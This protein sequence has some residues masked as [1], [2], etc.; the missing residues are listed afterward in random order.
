MASVDG[1]EYAAYT[2][3]Q[4]MGWPNELVGGGFGKDQFWIML[5][6]PAHVPPFYEVYFKTLEKAS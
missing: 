6:R 5:P 2:L 4:K 1:H 3:M